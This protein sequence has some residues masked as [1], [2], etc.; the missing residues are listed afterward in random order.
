MRDSKE[1]HRLRAL[2]WIVR[3]LEAHD[4]LTLKE[5]NE[6]WCADED[7]SDGMPIERRTFY[8]YKN[9]IAD[10]LKIV[11]ECD[12]RDENRYKIVARDDDEL[13]KWLIKSFTVNEILSNNADMRE[14]ILLEEIP[15]G[16]EFL[17]DIMG[18][19]RTGSKI[20]FEY[21]RFND[22]H[23]QK[24][25]GAPYCVKLYHQRWYVLVKEWRTLLV[26]HDVKE[27]MHVY[28]L[29]RIL[30]MK[31]TD[32]R[33][34]KD[35]QFDAK[36]YFQYAFGTRVEKDNPPQRVL[37]KV[38]DCQRDYLRTLPLHASQRKI[39]TQEEYSIFELH[40]AL[41]IELTMQILYYGSRVEVLE[42]AE[43]REEIEEEAYQL[44]SVYSEQSDE[45]NQQ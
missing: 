28:S 42:P 29:D 17:L 25:K 27:E 35:E 36:E 8:N 3:L 31:V 5:I 21:K 11:I 39:E 33:F 18:A 26:S 43:L 38:A 12:Q 34:E 40:V 13:S 1:N 44:N 16:Q 9:A 30:S 24:V 45:M 7:L 6:Y 23:V 22:C 41:T 10:L 2:L 37:L 15:A 19:M 32:E 14:R 4:A 20:A